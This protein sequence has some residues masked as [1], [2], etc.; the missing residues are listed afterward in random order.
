VARSIRG[1]DMELTGKLGIGTDE[2]IDSS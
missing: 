2:A 1:T